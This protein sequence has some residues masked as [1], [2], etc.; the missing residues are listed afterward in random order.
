MERTPEIYHSIIEGSGTERVEDRSLGVFAK[1]IQPP[2]FPTD[3]TPLEL[4][5]DTGVATV[6]C[7]SAPHPCRF[8]QGRGPARTA[9][10]ERA[11]LR[12]SAALAHRLCQ[13]TSDGGLRWLIACVVRGLRPTIP[14]PVSPDPRPTTWLSRSYPQQLP[15]RP[16]LW[17]SR[18]PPPR[19]CR[20]RLSHPTA[21]PADRP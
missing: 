18:S 6:K 12:K 9:A 16:R 7:N 5:T 1:I 10:L 20:Q 19:A 14:P 3:S 2:R 21:P 17:R 8:R 4:T 13:T 15:R 11:L